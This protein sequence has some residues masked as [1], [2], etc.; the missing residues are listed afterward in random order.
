M[1]VLSATLLALSVLSGVA[2]ASE[3]DCPEVVTNNA[4]G[5]L[6][7]DGSDRTPGAARAAEQ[8][9]IRSRVQTEIPEHL[10]QV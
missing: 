3:R 2:V 8:S 7:A 5:L 4:C 6:A 1:K 10:V 9:Q